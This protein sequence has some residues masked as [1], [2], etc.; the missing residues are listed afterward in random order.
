MAHSSP[1]LIFFAGLIICHRDSNFLKLQFRPFKGQISTKA[2][3]ANLLVFFCSLF[4][5]PYHFCGSFQSKTDIFAGLIICH[6]DSNFLKLQFRPFKGQI[7]TKAMRANLL[8]FF[9]SLFWRP[10][11]FCG[12]FQSKTDLFCWPDHL[13]QR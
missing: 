3:R 11:H 10:Y 5:R 8:V 9:C 12:S 13:P 1:K 6:R 2:M 7:S 4:W